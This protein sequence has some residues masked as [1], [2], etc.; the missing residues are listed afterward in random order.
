M[1]KKAFMLVARA[2]IVLGLAAPAFA[3]APA[4]APGAPRDEETKYQYL[5]D[6]ANAVVGVKVKALANARS[7]QSLGVERFGSGVAIDKGLV[8][9]IGYLILEADQVEVIN[10]QGRSVPAMVAAYDHATGF[11]LLRPLA[12][13]ETKPIKLGT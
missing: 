10:S 1:E 6:A 9:T 11:G 7:A 13:L 4:A 12:P 5:K 3:A 2:L 8:L